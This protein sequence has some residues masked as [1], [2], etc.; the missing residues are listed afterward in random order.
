[1][2]GPRGGVMG[3]MEGEFKLPEQESRQNPE[4]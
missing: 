1:M 4:P 3:V 2:T